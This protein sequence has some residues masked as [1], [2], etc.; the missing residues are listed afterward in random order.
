M[1]DSVGQQ[2]FHII[3]EGKGNV[4]SYDICGMVRALSEYLEQKY[5][6]SNIKPCTY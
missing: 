5:G 1:V 6:D 4:S 3:R 2:L